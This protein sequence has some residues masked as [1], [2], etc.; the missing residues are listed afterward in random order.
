MVKRKFERVNAAI[1]ELIEENRFAKKN[2]NL[3]HNLE[4]LLNEESCTEHMQFH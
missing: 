4:D 2:Q 3:T 1:E